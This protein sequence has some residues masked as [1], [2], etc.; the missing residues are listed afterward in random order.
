MSA[1]QLLLHVVVQLL[2][3]VGVFFL[4]VSSKGSPQL[5]QDFDGLGDGVPPAQDV[6]GVQGYHGFIDSL[7][8]ALIKD[9]DQLYRR[10]GE[11]AVGD[12]FFLAVNGIHAA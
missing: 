11:D 3:S 9:V 1:N 2:Q 6:A 7:H 5:R 10:R 4:H 8:G 12:V